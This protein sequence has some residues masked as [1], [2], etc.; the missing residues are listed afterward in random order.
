MSAADRAELPTVALSS[1]VRSAHQGESHGGVYLAD[2]ATSD[3][4]R[5]LDWNH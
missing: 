5:V 3:I 1:V 2:F 4:E